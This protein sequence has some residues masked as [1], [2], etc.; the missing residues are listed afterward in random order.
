VE[1]L[2][3]QPSPPIRA[4]DED[5]ART[6]AILGEH[7]RAGRLDTEEFEARCEEAWGAK[8]ISSL[9]TAVR[10]L[11][12]APPPPAQPAPAA[13]ASDAVV[14]FV[15]AV[16]SACILLMTFGLFS[17]VTLPGSAF[18]MRF[19]QRARKRGATGSHRGLASAAEAIG[20]IGIAVGLIALVLWIGL[21]SS[22]NE[23]G[24]D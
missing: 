24:V 20:F 16:V 22:M 1:S 18:G 3:T 8:M 7:Y 23:S 9:W 10:E 6:V 14:G 21:I 2:A 5:R 4:S 13:G 12:L 19:G 17:I 15:L 11:P